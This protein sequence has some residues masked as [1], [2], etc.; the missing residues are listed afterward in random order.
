MNPT[1]V[2]PAVFNHSHTAA[3]VEASSS[4]DGVCVQLLRPYQPEQAF[5]SLVL[6][7]NLAPHADGC[8][9]LEVQVEQDGQWSPFYKIGMLAHSFKQSFPAQQDVCGQ[10]AVDELRLTTPAQRYRCRIQLEG[11][12]F[13]DRLTT[14]GVCA[15]FVYDEPSATQ[16]P[17]GEV[18]IPV[19]AISQKEQNLADKDRICSPV[20]LCMAL[21]AL[22]Q[23]V[24]LAQVLEGVYDATYDIYG[25]WMFN[26]AFAAQCG[27]EAE[28]RRFSSLKQLLDTCTPR[29]LVVASVAY[30]AGE[31]P[32]AAQPQTP[33]HLVL[34]RGY[35]KGKILV[36]DP[37]APHAGEVLRAYEAKAF[38]RAWLCNKQGVA[39]V[40]R[41]K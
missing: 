12:T 5:S 16:L 6:S 34:V 27:V 14:C 29:S 31:L 22:G 35:E 28:V 41:K 13:L 25:N 23:R 37:A 4:S 24:T 15:P 39:Y 19:S 7:A 11:N 2:S 32:H 38:A 33:G 17:A 21:Q 40:L 9:L 18:E 30:Q 20:S 26:V 1:R 36:A 8:A 10:V 3:D